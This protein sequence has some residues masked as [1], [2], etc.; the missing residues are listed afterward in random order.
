MNPGQ[1]KV[2]AI[3]KA[4]CFERRGCIGWT[5][6]FISLKQEEHYHLFHWDILHWYSNVGSNMCNA[7][8]EIYF[9]AYLAVHMWDC[10]CLYI[11]DFSAI[12]SKYCLKSSPQISM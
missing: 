7:H 2:D 4:G 1:G 12:T 3:C 5:Q 8:L 6:V 9:W 11:Q 10:V